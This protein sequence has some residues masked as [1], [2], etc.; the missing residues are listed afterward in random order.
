[1]GKRDW[2]ALLLDAKRRGITQTMLAR[3][4]GCAKSS[5][6]EACERHNVRLPMGKTGRAPKTY[7]QYDA[8]ISDVLAGL[9]EGEF[10]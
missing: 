5:V 8:E 7:E 10:Q 9:D 3:E 6:G 2:P 4:Q 1:M